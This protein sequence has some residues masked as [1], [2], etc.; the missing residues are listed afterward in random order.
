C[1]TA[2]FCRASLRR[3]KTYG[4]LPM[5]NR[6]TR[7]MGRLFGH[8]LLF[9]AAT[10]LT[11]AAVLFALIAP[12]FALLGVSAVPFTA[13]IAMKSIFCALLG[14]A[15]AIAGLYAGLCAPQ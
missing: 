13:Y 11:S 10:G 6:L 14:G 9:G 5:K 3:T 1:I 7:L 8:I 15:A 2:P 12:V 4:I